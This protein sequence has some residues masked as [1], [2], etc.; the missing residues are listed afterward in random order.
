MTT[1]SLLGEG[2]LL[3][4]GDCEQCCACFG[5]GGA[6]RDVGVGVM[7]AMM[8]ESLDAWWPWRWRCWSFSMHELLDPV[9]WSN[10]VRNA[11]GVS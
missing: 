3:G 4:L 8:S 2:H 7:A 1:A 9:D 10:K 11:R 6:A 5:R